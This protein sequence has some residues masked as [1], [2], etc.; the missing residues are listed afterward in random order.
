MIRSLGFIEELLGYRF[1]NPKLLEV[2][3]T[4]S[5]AG[6]N[7]NE[8][9]EF[10]GDAI[11][12]FV[13]GNYLFDKFPQ[14]QEGQLSRMRASL[15]KGDALAELAKSFKLSDVLVLGPGEV[16][17]NGNCRSSILA[18][19]MEALIGAVYLDSDFETCRRCV[20]SWYGDT[21]TNITL[22]QQHIDAKTQLQ[23]LLQARR[24]ALPNY[25]VVEQTGEVHR[26]LFRV[27]CRVEAL[28]ESTEAQGSNR[29][30]AEQAAATLMIE[31]IQHGH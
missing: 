28:N 14:A 17:M 23:E 25:V 6:K 29:R 7:N 20:L 3:L 13:V 12:N 1:L 16:R 26:Q 18:G 30:Q 15:V 10:L 22:E 2:A 19:T 24:L 8:R 11:V 5:S 4:H 31:R 27:A 9:V 21:L